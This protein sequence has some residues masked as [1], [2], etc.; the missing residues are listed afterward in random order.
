[1]TLDYFQKPTSFLV[2][3]V[4]QFTE[5]NSII[6][7][8]FSFFSAM[9]FQ[10]TPPSGTPEELPCGKRPVSEEVTEHPR[11]LTAPWVVLIKDF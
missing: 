4:Y 9:V 1:M 8:Y 6:W 5:L 2:L 10:T 11:V 3:L 7:D